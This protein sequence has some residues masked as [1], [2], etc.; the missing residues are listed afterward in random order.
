MLRHIQQ[1]LVLVIERAVDN[2]SSRGAQTQPFLSK[3]KRPATA[4]VAESTQRY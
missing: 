1:R 2:E 4:S 3:V